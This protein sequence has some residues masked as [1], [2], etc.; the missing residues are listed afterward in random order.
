[1]EIILYQSKRDYANGLNFVLDT[2]YKK[3]EKSTI[4]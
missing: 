2:L 3:L 4:P 1:M